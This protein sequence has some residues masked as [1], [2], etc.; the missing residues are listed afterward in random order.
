M[1]ASGDR[2]PAP[3]RTC[4]GCGRRAGKGE[5]LRLAVD[6]AGAVE[7]DHAMVAPGRGVYL[8]PNDD[9][10]RRAQRRQPAGA[11]RRR[12]DAAALRQ[13]LARAAEEFKSRG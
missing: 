4:F 6:A 12:V 11:L 2:A 5:L 10:F 1:N 8:C 3:T 7:F 13:A 9:C